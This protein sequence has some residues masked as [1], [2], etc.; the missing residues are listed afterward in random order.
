MGDFGSTFVFAFALI[1]RV[2][3]SIKLVLDFSLSLL[4]RNTFF[5]NPNV[6]VGVGTRGP[7]KFITFHDTRSQG[8]P[9]S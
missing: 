1:R 9:W 3:T 6:A 5:N 4:R 2:R 8:P 7:S